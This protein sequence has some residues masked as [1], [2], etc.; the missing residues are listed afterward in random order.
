MAARVLVA[1]T[2]W[3]P[4]VGVLASALEQAG[5]DVVV[6][7]PRGHVALRAGHFTCRELDRRR[8]AASLADAIRAIEP[9][10]VAAGDDR[11]VGHLRDLYGTYP[12]LR[13][14]IERSLGAVACH[15][16]L[17]SRVGLLEAA[18]R[19]GFA[20]PPSRA[21]R[22]DAD[23]ESWMDQVPGPWV[24]KVDSAWGGEGVR[25]VRSRVAAHR[26]RNELRSGMPAALAFK[27]RVLNGDPMPWQERRAAS[28]RHISV[29]GFIEGRPTTCALFTKGGEVLG[30]TTLEAVATCGEHGP[31]TF[32]RA[33]ERPDIVANARRLAERLGIS[34]F[35][36]LDFLVD[37]HG[38]ARLIEMNP[39]ITGPCRMRGPAGLDPI[40]AASRAF[41]CRPRRPPPRSRTLFASFPLAWLD[42][43]SSPDL[44]ACREDLPWREPAMLREALRPLWPE[45][46]VL[47]FLPARLRACRRWLTRT[48]MRPDVRLKPFAW[49]QAQDSFQPPDLRDEDADAAPIDTTQLPLCDPV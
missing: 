18:A 23:L 40:T 38:V 21:I 12:D 2:T 31:A 7:C 46:G 24:V 37:R 25:I 39:R 4:S 10:L 17:T 22:S 6:L 29:Q 42:D 5:F 28:A 33:V 13:E 19:A 26:A 32:L 16:V 35:I 1:T 9:T 49:W 47:A 27:R 36:G 34:G 8:P 30:A 45:R 15:E 41:G 48:D 44:L 3:W 20:V 43:P 14:L 11:A